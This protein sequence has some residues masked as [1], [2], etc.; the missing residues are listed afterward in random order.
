MTPAARSLPCASREHR[1]IERSGRRRRPAARD[2]IRETKQFDQRGTRVNLRSA[3]SRPSGER[4][5]P[6]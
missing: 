1:K 4:G 6:A 2:G 5:H 3:R